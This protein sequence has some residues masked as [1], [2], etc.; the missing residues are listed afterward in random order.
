MWVG[1]AGGRYALGVE[2]AGMAP[3]SCVDLLPA[4]LSS[5]CSTSTMQHLQSSWQMLVVAVVIIVDTS[6]VV[7][8]VVVNTSDVAVHVISVISVVFGLV[9]MGYRGGEVLTLGPH[10]IESE[11]EG[12]NNGMHDGEKM[13]GGGGGKEGSNVATVHVVSTFRRTWAT[14]LK[15]GISIFNLHHK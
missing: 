7:A 8:V 9:K 5:C 10:D 12:A 15:I 14:G 2:T 13:G 11:R 1:G 4:F 6:D 3:P